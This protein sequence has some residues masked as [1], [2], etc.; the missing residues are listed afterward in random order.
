MKISEMWLRHDLVPAT[1]KDLTSKELRRGEDEKV[2][3]GGKVYRILDWPDLM[4]IDCKVF[5]YLVET[6]Q[7]IRTDHSGF[8]W[9]QI[10]KRSDYNWPF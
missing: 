4:W 7:E 5:Q 9:V 8:N 3:R 6:S 10:G 2:F 1:D